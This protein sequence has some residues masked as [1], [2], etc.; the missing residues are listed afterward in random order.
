M[1]TTDEMKYGFNVCEP[2]CVS[3]KSR[4]VIGTLR[5]KIYD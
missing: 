2:F 4:N 3:S 5:N 1:C